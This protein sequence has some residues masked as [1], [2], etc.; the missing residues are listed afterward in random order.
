MKQ[1]LT[2][3]VVFTYGIWYDIRSADRPDARYTFLKAWQDPDYVPWHGALLTPEEVIETILSRLVH[4]D[5]MRDDGVV[6]VDTRR[7]KMVIINGVL[8]SERMASFHDYDRYPVDRDRDRDRYRDRDFSRGG[9]RTPRR[10][11]K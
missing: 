8:R 3:Q 7:S 1:L 4:K 5:P 9:R 11:R 10:P 2:G 6:Y